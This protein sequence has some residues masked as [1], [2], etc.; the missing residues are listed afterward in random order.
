MAVITRPKQTPRNPSAPGRPKVRTANSFFCGKISTIDRL[1]DRRPVLLGQGLP[2]PRQQG[3]DPGA[4][5]VGL[6]GVHPDDEPVAL[7][8]PEPGQAV[9]EGDRG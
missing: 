2:G 9:A 6:A 3:Q 4:V 5:E 8:G 1:G 7:Q